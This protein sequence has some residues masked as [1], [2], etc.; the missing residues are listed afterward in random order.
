[1]QI[2]DHHFSAL[3]KAPQPV[4]PPAASAKITQDL[5]VL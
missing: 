4:D 1:M 2:T 3:C 5:H